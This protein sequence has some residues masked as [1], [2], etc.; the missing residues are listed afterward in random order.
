MGDDV[1]VDLV[2]LGGDIPRGKAGLQEASQVAFRQ[3][4]DG[5]PGRL[6]VGSFCT[7][8]TTAGIPAAY[9]NSGSI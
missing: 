6:I 7:S 2:R 8:S 4:Q 1:L 5:P 3:L 9:R